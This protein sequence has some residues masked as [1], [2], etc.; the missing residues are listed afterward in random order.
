MTIRRLLQRVSLPALLTGSFLV[1]QVSASVIDCTLLI[2]LRRVLAA[3]VLQGYAL[4]MLRNPTRRSRL[5]LLNR[6]H[7][8]RI[9]HV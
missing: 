1:I 6:S 4:N 2:E 5:K 9:S 3:H 7:N 8:R